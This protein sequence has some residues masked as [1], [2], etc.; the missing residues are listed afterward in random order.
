[1]VKKENI[2]EYVKEYFVKR[3]G[4]Y[5]KQFDENDKK[6]FSYFL[7]SVEKELSFHDDEFIDNLLDSYS[8]GFKYLFKKYFCDLNVGGSI[9]GEYVSDL[10]HC[11]ANDFVADRYDWQDVIEKSLRYILTSGL[12]EKVI[13][14]IEREKEAAFECFIDDVVSE[15][16]CYP[17]NEVET[18]LNGDGAMLWKFEKQ[19]RDYLN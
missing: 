2:G 4:Y 17:L 16:S 5:I 8:N 12:G 11:C 19:F 6:E 7:D 13:E 18:T 14:K 9:A 3:F 15:Y 10:P 1:M